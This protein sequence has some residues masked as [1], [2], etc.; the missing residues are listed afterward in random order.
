[1][2]AA[3][4][5]TQIKQAAEYG[6]GCDQRVAARLRQF[7]DTHALGLDAAQGLTA[8]ETF[9]LDLDDAT[10]AWISASSPAAAG[11]PKH[12]PPVWLLL[13]DRRRMLPAR[14]ISLRPVLRWR[15][16]EHSA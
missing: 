9:L 4:P 10:R 14:L 2:P 13:R 8:A 6:L 7:P 16:D 11:G 5:S 3:T 1:M 12:N 15:H